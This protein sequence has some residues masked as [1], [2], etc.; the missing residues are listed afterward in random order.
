MEPAARSE[1]W[2]EMIRPAGSRSEI[3]CAFRRRRSLWMPRSG[4]GRHERR[5]ARFEKRRIWSLAPRR[6]DGSHAWETRTVGTQLRGERSR[7]GCLEPSWR[8]RTRSCPQPMPSPNCASEDRHVR[9]TASGFRRTAGHGGQT[10]E[11]LRA[12]RSFTRELPVEAGRGAR[13]PADLGHLLDG[14]R[15]VERREAELP[16][17]RGL[18]RYAHSHTISIVRT[19]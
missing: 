13:A 7:F 3:R 2:R 16:T 19:E 6:R 5:I 8:D 9:V 15:T 18:C 17:R 4:L 1:S 12:A 10:R 14:H 11:R